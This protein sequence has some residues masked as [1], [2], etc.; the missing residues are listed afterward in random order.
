MTITATNGNIESRI[1]EYCKDIVQEE[2]CY[3]LC[4]TDSREWYFCMAAHQNGN[5]YIDCIVY[6]I[7]YD[8]YLPQNPAT[9]IFMTAQNVDTVY[10]QNPQNYMC[11]TS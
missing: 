6:R 10:F 5:E 4:G 1:V 2:Y 11:Y 9:T 3:F 7:W 8:T